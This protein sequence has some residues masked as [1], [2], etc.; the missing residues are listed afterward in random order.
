M[1]IQTLIVL[2]APKLFFVTCLML[3]CV[4]FNG[5]QDGQRNLYD[6]F[7]TIIVTS[8]TSL[9]TV[10]VGRYANPTQSIAHS[11]EIKNI[12]DAITKDLN[13]YTHFNDKE[14]IKDMLLPA[15]LK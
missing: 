3:L 13:D 4:L 1:A 12:F 15:F 14:L 2:N 8:I 9:Y 6:V 11:D 10:Y 5:S 7:Q